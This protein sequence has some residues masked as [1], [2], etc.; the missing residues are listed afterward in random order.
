[1]LVF[2]LWKKIAVLLV[3]LAGVY[4]AL[5]TAFPALLKSENKFLPSKTINL[6]LDLRGGSHLLLEVDVAAYVREQAESLEEQIR[7]TL[8]KEKIGYKNLGRNGM[9]VNVEITD[10][11]QKEKASALLKDIDSRFVFTDA[12]NKFTAEFSEAAKTEAND[13]VLEQSIEIVRRRVDETGTREPIIQRQGKDRIIL[14]VPGLEDPSQLKSMLGKTAKLTF[15]MVDE[16][17]QPNGPQAAGMPLTSM[18][19]PFAEKS[20]NLAQPY[21]AVERKALLSGD[22]L[23]KA[24]ATMDNNGA[25][26]VSFGFNSTGSKKFADA[27]S[28]NVDKRFAVIL[29]GQVITAP[30]IREPIIG[31]SGQISGN[32]TVQS[33]NE[34]ALLLRA[35]ALPAPLKVIEERTVGPSLGIDSVE[36]GTNASL[37]ALALVAVF[38]LLYYRLFGLFADIALA[39]NMVLIVAVLALLQATL[40]LPGI[41]GIILTIGMAVDANVL[42]YERMREEVRMGKTVFAAIDSGFNRAFTTILDSNLT[43]LIAAILLYHYGSGPV[44]GFAVTLSVGIVTSMFTAVMFTRMLI[45]MWARKFNPK[46]L[47]L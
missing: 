24:M 16:S 9:S 47:P 18:I 39:V 46:T 10:Q 5:P 38:M 44:K 43:G 29:D 45:I 35:G 13:L 1:M 40:T 11:A 4:V 42:I 37:L 20:T 3:C 2:P 28:Q 36:D 15:H 19:V 33:A 23:V 27:T 26:V 17:V 7:T 21:I 32:F 41:A 31:G 30:V 22:M 12:D 8:R 6:G 25:A 34:L 14:Q